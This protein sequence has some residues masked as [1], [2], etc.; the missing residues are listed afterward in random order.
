[1][2]YGQCDIM[3]NGCCL[4]STMPWFRSELLSSVGFKILLDQN[5][6]CAQPGTVMHDSGAN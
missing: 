4:F 1:M 2:Y 6:F 3:N 5:G